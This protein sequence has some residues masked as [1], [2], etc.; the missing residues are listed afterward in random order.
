[1]GL[2]LTVTDW[3]VLSTVPVFSFVTDQSSVTGATALW[4]DSVTTGISVSILSIAT[5]T[6]LNSLL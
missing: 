3:M 2:P 6:A 1:M 5:M 4:A